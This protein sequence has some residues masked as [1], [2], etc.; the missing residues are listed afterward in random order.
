[1]TVVSNDPIWWPWISYIHV[2]C[3]F[4]V[5]SF[6]VVLYDWGEPC[7]AYRRN[8]DI[9]TT[10]ALTFG[11][12][13]ELVWRQ[14]WSLM[15]ILYLIVRYTGMPYII[16]MISVHLLSCSATAFRFFNRCS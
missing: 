1:M 11:Q 7:N 12:E 13:F 2:S 10:P 3:Y 8:V 16:L 9:P 5:V 6:T 15:T 14:R 4:S